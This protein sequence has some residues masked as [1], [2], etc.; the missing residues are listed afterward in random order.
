MGNEETVVELI[1]KYD[2]KLARM[3]SGEEGLKGPATLNQNPEALAEI[4]CKK[5]EI[6]G[7]LREQRREREE[8]EEKERTREAEEYNDIK[9]GKKLITPQWDDGE[10][11]QGYVVHGSA[12]KALLEIG[13]AKE[14]GYRTIAPYEAVK[15]LGTTFSYPQALD[16]IKPERDKKAKLEDERKRDLEA[17]YSKAKKEGVPV[18]IRKYTM[19]C[20]DSTEECS[21][22]IISVYAQPDGTEKTTRTHTY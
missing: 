22:D 14:L 10:Y 17:K 8:R 21:L 4:R 12:A 15:T 3:P 11:W 19:E 2:L 16:Y 13:F 20:T 18:L 6:M 9:A 5:I 1:R 7:F